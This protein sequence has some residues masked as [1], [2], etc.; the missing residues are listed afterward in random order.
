MDY[1]TKNHLR[2]RKRTWSS[3]D[4]HKKIQQDEKKL[5]PKMCF[6]TLLKY[7][8][9]WQMIYQNP[10]IFNTMSSNLDRLN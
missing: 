2:E 9:T 10:D 5:I 7:I 8:E 4:N 1:D 6:L 3:K